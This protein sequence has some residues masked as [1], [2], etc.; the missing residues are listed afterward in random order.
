LVRTNLSVPVS[1]QDETLISLSAR[2][3]IKEILRFSE[4]IERA[5]QAVEGHSPLEA[6][7]LW[8]LLAAGRL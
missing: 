5:R 6:V 4:Y 1:Y 8:L 7:L 3:K 2:V